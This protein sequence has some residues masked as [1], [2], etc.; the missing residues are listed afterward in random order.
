MIYL[1]LNLFTIFGPLVLSFD[2]RVAFYKKWAAALPA[3]L[4]SVIFFVPWDAFFTQIGVWGFTPKY[5]LGMK[6]RENFSADEAAQKPPQV[7][8]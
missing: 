8:F 5:L 6:V 2:R 3:V 1:Y 4:V 7:K